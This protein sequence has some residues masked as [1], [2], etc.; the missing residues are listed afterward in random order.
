MIMKKKYKVLV[1][2]SCSGRFGGEID[3]FVKGERHLSLEACHCLVNAGYAEVI[4][5]LPELP[6]KE[7][8]PDPPKDGELPLDFP[9]RD[10]L[11]ENELIT[12]A[13]VRE[14]EDLTTLTGIGEAK[15]ADIAEALLKLG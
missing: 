12:I 15:A 2:Q 5:E 9:M 1:L 13:E 7:V 11:I 4:D 6:K 10:L 3:S 14:F 8:V